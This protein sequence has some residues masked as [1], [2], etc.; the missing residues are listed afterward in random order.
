LQHRSGW[1][2]FQPKGLKPR[3]GP[4]FGAASHIRLR[5]AAFFFARL[6]QAIVF[7]GDPIAGRSRC[8]P[9]MR[10][11][12][13]PSRLPPH[14]SEL[15]AILAA[16]LVR[17]RRHT[18]EKFAEDAARLGGEAENSLHLVAHQSGHANLIF[19]RMA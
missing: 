7:A 9:T 10:E 17:L 13:N 8:V 4:D 15:C 12:L 3:I 14:L 1:V 16:G 18:Q 6:R 11:A 5:G 2:I 19:R